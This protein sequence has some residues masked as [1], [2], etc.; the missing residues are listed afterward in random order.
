MKHTIK[1]TFRRFKSDDIGRLAL[2]RYDDVGRVDTMVIKINNEGRDADVYDFA[3]KHLANVGHDQVCEIGGY[4][5]P[6]GKA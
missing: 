4:I 3:C 5:Q 6:I 2:V 1:K